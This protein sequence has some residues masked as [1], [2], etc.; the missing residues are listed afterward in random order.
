MVSGYFQITFCRKRIGYSSQKRFQPYMYIP[1]DDFIEDF[2][3]Y[4]LKAN[5]LVRDPPDYHMIQ[6]KLNLQ[7][8]ENIKFQK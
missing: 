5:K 1:L 8:M 7:R 4:G 6:E 3:N 2:L